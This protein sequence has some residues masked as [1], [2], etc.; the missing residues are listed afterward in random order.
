MI[1]I[2]PSINDTLL[3]DDDD[4][5]EKQIKAVLKILLPVLSGLSIPP[6]LVNIILLLNFGIFT[7]PSNVL[8]LNLILLDLINCYL[9]L[10][11]TLNDLD[12]DKVWSRFNA[13]LYLF[14]FDAYIVLLLGLTV[15]RVLCVKMSALSVLHKLHLV[16]RGTVVMAAVWGVFMVVY[17][18]LVPG[19]QP[20]VIWF[21]WCDIGEILMV[22]AAVILALYTWARV[23]Y[24]YTSCHTYKAATY[25]CMLLVLNYMISYSW[26]FV[27]NMARFYYTIINKNVP[28][29]G[30][31]VLLFFKRNNSVVIGIAFMAAQ[32]LCLN[33]FC[34]GKTS[35]GT[36]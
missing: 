10:T 34:C 25:T 4:T 13:T 7:A 22:L 2:P 29:S 33:L 23:R 26:Y 30:L 31:F 20:D 6:S 27:L 1:L 19:E 18:R 24:V 17:P 35:R 8:Y 16:S 28:D 5:T 36:R 14:S 11:L 9:A 21:L 3:E 32:T 12:V 15:L